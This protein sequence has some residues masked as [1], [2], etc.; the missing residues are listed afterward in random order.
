[1]V[2][3][4]YTLGLAEGMKVLSRNLCRKCWKER[5]PQ[6]KKVI[7]ENAESWYCPRKMPGILTRVS[8][9]STIPRKCLKLFEQTVYQAM[10]KKRKKGRK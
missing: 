7:Q 10:K 9:K 3:W 4:K 5:R 2:D 1:M 6:L 8:K